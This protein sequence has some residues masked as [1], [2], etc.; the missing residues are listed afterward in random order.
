VRRAHS[1]HIIR[2]MAALGFLPTLLTAP[3]VLPYVLAGARL[4]IGFAWVFV[5]LLMRFF[6]M[7]WSCSQVRF[8]R[9]WLAARRGCVTARCVG[10]G[11]LRWQNY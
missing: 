4:V 11:L 6:A 10:I 3:I 2:C 1:P 5:T 8:R 7:F 9:R